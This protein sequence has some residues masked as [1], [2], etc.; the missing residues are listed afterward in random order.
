MFG[1]LFR[2]ELAGQL[3]GIIHLGFQ[4]APPRQPQPMTVH[5]EVTRSGYFY[6]NRNL[7]SR[8]IC[9]RPLAGPLSVLCLPEVLSAPPYLLLHVRS[10]SRSEGYLWP[11]LYL[12]PLSFIALIPMTLLTHYLLSLGR[13]DTSEK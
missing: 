10:T 12:F 6:P 2:E 5:S 3:Q 13:T 7:L 4:A 9:S 1:S 11:F 8:A